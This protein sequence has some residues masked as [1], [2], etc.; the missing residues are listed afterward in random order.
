MDTRQIELV[1][2]TFAL[3]KPNADA[4]AAMFYG[5][6]FEI[7]PSVRPLFKSSVE[8]QGKKLMA[9]L[10]LAVEGLNDVTP[11]IPALTAL[12]QSHVGYGAQPEHYDTVG[13]ALL[14]TLSQGLGD[15]FTPEVEAAWTAAYVLLAGVMKDAAAKMNH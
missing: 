7:A 8:A 12:G 9:T 2:T 11:L 13:Q 5:R 6:L 4:V 10:A 1:Q 15:K 3:V 14:W